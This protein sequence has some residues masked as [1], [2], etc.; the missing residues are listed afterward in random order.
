MAAIPLMVNLKNKKAVIVGGGKVA[1]RRAKTILES[2]AELTV[3]SPEAT[4]E[5]QKWHEEGKIHWK[6]KAFS[7]ED[8]DGASLIIIAT[9]DKTVNTAVRKAAPSASLVNEATNAEAGNVHFPSHLKRGKLSISVSTNGASP[10]LAKK[11]KRELEARYT[12]DYGEYMEFLYEAR[13]LVKEAALSLKE[14][15]VYLEAFLSEK[16]FNQNAQREIIEHLKELQ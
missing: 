11:I 9:N 8:V 2:E 1:R 16:Y 7:P 6:K 3:V 5:I 15:E 12:E 13:K 10:L 14:K 4:S